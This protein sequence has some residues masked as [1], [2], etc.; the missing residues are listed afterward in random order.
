MSPT[1][2]VID[3]EVQIRRLLRIVLEGAG[4]KVVQAENGILGIQQAAGTRPDMVLLDMGLPDLSGLEVLARLREWSRVPVI[5]LTVQNDEADKISALDGGADDY[6]T[7]PFASG[8]LLARI[9]AGLRRVEP[10]A[11]TAVFSQDGLEVDLVSRTVRK[12][13]AP[14]NVTPT[15]W[16]LL[17]LLIRHAGRIVTHKQILRE[18]WGPG[19]EDHGSYLR[20]YFSHLRKKVERNPAVPS[21]ILNEPGVGYRLHIKG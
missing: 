4:Y 15:E 6:V 17:T 20:V 13:G 3:D 5:V 1:V 21:L 18:I 12:D 16:G 9:R 11:E 19:S 2:L 10:Q 14:V 7:K 8:E